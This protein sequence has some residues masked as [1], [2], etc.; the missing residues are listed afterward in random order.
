[1][2]KNKILLAIQNRSAVIGKWK[3]VYIPTPTI[4]A[5]LT[6]LDG[7]VT[8]LTERVGNF[9]KIIGIEPN[10]ANINGGIP[11]KKRFENQK[12]EYIRDMISETREMSVGVKTQK[13]C[14]IDIESWGPSYEHQRSRYL[15]FIDPDYTKGYPYKHALAWEKNAIK[16]FSSAIKTSSSIAKYTGIFNMPKSFMFDPL[17]NSED[18]S[19]KRQAYWLESATALYPECYWRPNDNTERYITRVENKLRIANVIADGRPIIPFISQTLRGQFDLVPQNAIIEFKK[20]IDKYDEV[21]LW[22]RASNVDTLDEFI[23]KLD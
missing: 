3:N 19:N 9:P 12:N 6:I 17:K 14:V 2:N 22:S 11:T 8:V 10:T 13:H 23:A 16:W 5:N 7:K 1:M 20:L 21:I 18:I 15:S 4:S